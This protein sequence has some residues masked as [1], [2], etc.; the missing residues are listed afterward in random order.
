M[1]LSH[2]RQLT[3]NLSEYNLH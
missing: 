2:L 1:L 3:S